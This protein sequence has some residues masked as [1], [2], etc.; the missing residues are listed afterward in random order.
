MKSSTIYFVLSF[1]C[2]V[3]MA[4]CQK[5]NKLIFFQVTLN[6]VVQPISLGEIQLRGNIFNTSNFEEID[7]VGFIWSTDLNDI[8]INQI[9]STW[10]EATLESNGSFTANLPNLAINSV[11][12]FRA[13]AER[14][15]PG[16][17]TRLVFSAEVETFS[18][19]L[20]LS[21]SPDKQRSN[22]NMIIEAQI[23]GL[24]DN[25]LSVNQYGFDLS[26]DLAFVEN[27]NEYVVGTSKNDD[28][29]FTDTL[30]NLNF[31]THYYV[32]AWAEKTN[33]EKFFSPVDSFW[34]RDGWYQIPNLQFQTGHYG[35]LLLVVN[36]LVECLAGQ[37]K[38]AYL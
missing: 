21:L 14:T 32:R 31:N 17:G 7:R 28:G 10:I 8:Q 23:S 12:Y 11:Y 35:C 9:S 13:F 37:S 15:E 2:V 24:E 6:E 33:G 25:N 1:L 5:E 27:M 30:K 22:N 18:F 20:R 16:L 34:I 26:T 29:P 19:Q 4:A 3:L 38:R 36:R